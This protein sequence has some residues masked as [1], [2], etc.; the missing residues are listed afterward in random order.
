MISYIV[1]LHL[2]RVF[3]SLFSL[4]IYYTFISFLLGLLVQWFFF[5]RFYCFCTGN[6]ISSNGALTCMLT[7]GLSHVCFNLH[8]NCSLIFVAALYV[9]MCACAVF[10]L[11]LKSISLCTCIVKSNK[12]LIFY[13]Q[14]RRILRM[15]N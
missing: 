9:C 15:R 1:E 6:C 10:V 3:L 7:A 13:V 2:I 11:L 5:P 4:Y 12:L 8:V 14:C